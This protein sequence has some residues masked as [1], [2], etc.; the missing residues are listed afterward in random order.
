M[1]N[2][3]QQTKKY[4][5]F[6]SKLNTALLLILII[7]MVVALKWM[8]ENKQ[9]YM[10][11]ITK[12]YNDTP[13]DVRDSYMS[14]YKDTDNSI[15]IA[16][17]RSLIKE[18][19]DSVVFECNLLDKKYFAFHFD[20]VQN[21]SHLLGGGTELYNPEGVSVDSCSMNPNSDQSSFCK[22]FRK[23]NASCKEVYVKNGY[24]GSVDVYNLSN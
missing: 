17:F 23:P 7:F 14:D 6:G 9:V 10:H 3:Q 8:F 21:G 15:N 18:W 5:F 11:V 24:E 1:E 12:Q 20:K 2:E 4:W 16:F 13:T 19:P 22:E